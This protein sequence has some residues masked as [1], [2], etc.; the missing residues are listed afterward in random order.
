MAP[1]GNEVQQQAAKPGGENF[2]PALAIELADP[3]ALVVR[4]RRCAASSVLRY[5]EPDDDFV[6]EILDL[7]AYVDP[8]G[9]LQLRLDYNAHYE[10]ADIR[11]GSCRLNYSGR[12]S[13]W[14]DI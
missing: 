14:W 7:E 1:S 5:L 13:V 2:R 3:G 9:V 8:A 10:G 12:Y 6:M 4:A 11:T